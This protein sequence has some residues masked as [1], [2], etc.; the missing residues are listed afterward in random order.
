MTAR[1]P[2][3]KTAS[4]PHSALSSRHQ[5]AALAAGGAL[6]VAAAM[7]QLRQSAFPAGPRSDAGPAWPE[8]ATL[9]LGYF[10][11]LFLFA[12]AVAAIYG[13]VV[14]RRRSVASSDGEAAAKRGRP[15][16][17]GGDPDDPDRIAN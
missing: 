10:S 8:L 3:R 7:E 1:D 13:A 4:P 16:A 2:A 15:D 11:F 9:V 5:L 12:V 17:D 14:P 6:A